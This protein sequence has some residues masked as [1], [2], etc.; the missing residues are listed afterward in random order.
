MLSDQ[1][2]HNHNFIANSN[3]R[4][5]KEIKEKI[6][7]LYELRI[8]QPLNIIYRL[9]ANKKSSQ[10]I[11]VVVS[12]RYLLELASKN[13][14]TCIDATYQLIYQCHPVIMCS[15]VDKNK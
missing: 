14:F 9:L 10:Y 2:E 8:T 1:E 7:E 6:F 12:T 13:V 3:K 5:R 11:R 4:L 15:H